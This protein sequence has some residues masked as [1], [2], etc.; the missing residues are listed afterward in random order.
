MLHSCGSWSQYGR[1]WVPGATLQPDAAPGRTAS[2][3]TCRHPPCRPSATLPT[4][5]LTAAA[6]ADSALHSGLAP[7]LS[8]S[9]LPTSPSSAY[10]ISPETQ[11]RIRF[12]PS[13][14]HHLNRGRN[15]G[16][17]GCQSS[18][19]TT[20]KPPASRQRSTGRRSSTWISGHKPTYRYQ[21]GIS[22]AGTR[23]YASDLLA[24]RSCFFLEHVPG[25][26]SGCTVSFP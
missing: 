1:F 9:L 4:A 2:L 12:V 8:A 3:R 15:R 17:A 7:P 25:R 22:R 21:S 18:S 19:T 24:F 23:S 14:G 16:Q 20:R 5:A 11:H 26:S 6:T 13:S 10:S